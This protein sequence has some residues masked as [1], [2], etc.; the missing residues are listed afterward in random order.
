MPFSTSYLVD[1]INIRGT[2]RSSECTGRCIVDAS[3]LL[4]LAPPSTLAIKYT[5]NSITFVHVPYF[6]QAENHNSI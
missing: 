3:F 1:E 4:Y 5:N 6:E 2:N